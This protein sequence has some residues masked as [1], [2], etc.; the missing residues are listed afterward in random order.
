MEVKLQRIQKDIDDIENN[1]VEMEV[2]KGLGKIDESIV[3]KIIQRYGEELEGRKVLY[4]DIE[5][6]IDDLGKDKNWL[7]WIEKYGEQ[8]ELQTSNEEKQKNFLKGVLKSITI[9]SEYDKN[10]DG[11]EV[12]KGHS[13]EFKFKLKIV[14]D[15]YQVISNQTKPRNY[16]VVEGKDRERSEGVMRFISKRNRTLKKRKKVTQEKET[17]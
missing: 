13:V 14:D 5:K 8:L 4:E 10:R 7:N 17:T 1:I 16:R 12:Q 2:S 15:E 6:Q 9:K 11:K 3:K